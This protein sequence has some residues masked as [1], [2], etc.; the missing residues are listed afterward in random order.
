MYD[1][2]SKKI[3]ELIELAKVEDDTNTQIILLALRSSKYAHRDGML[4]KAV[5]D[6]LK[7]VLLPLIKEE[8]EG[9]NISL[10]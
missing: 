9:N 5:Q 7:S 10:N 6:Y 1:L 4:A 8:K 3:D 2:I